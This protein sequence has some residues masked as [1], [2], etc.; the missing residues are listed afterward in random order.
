[1]I[2]NEIAAKLNAPAGRPQAKAAGAAHATE[3]RG[4]AAEAQGPGAENGDVVTLSKSAVSAARSEPATAA[5]ADERAAGL[6]AQALRQAIA[7]QPER[8][9]GAFSG[10]SNAAPQLAALLSA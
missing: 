3:E 1:M 10:L 6:E 9:R 2:I 4:E 8:A 5:I 7:A